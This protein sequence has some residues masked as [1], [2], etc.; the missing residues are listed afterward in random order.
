MLTWQ[1]AIQEYR[2]S[3]TIVHKAGKMHWNSDGLSRWAL[4]NTP[5]NPAF[6]PLEAKPQIPI[7]GINITDIGTE[8]FEE[9][10]ESQKQD[11]NCHILTSLLDKY[12]KD[13]SLLNALDEVWK[14]SYS[15]GRFHLFEGIIYHRTKDSCVMT[16]CIR[17]L[18]NTILHECH[19]IIYSGHLSEDRTLEKVKNCAWWPSL[20]KETIEYCHTCDRC[21]KAN[22]STGKIFGLMIHIQD[23]KSP[24]EVV[25]MDWVTALP[26]S[27]DRGYNAC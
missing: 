7:E 4:A 15:E 10:R 21:Q 11:N 6:V 2:G 9:F 25:H 18:I 5:D 20:R 17:S 14:N 26:P 24:W 19:D 1:I 27:G 23:Q 13:T 3:M 8:F 12:C 16:L 22:R